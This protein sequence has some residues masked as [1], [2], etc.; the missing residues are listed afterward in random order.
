MVGDTGCDGSGVVSTFTVVF[1]AAFAAHV[2]KV[3]TSGYTVTAVSDEALVAKYNQK[4]GTS[5]AV[6]PS[7]NIIIS[8]A[9]P[10]TMPTIMP[11]PMPFINPDV[12]FFIFFSFG[13]N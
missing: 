2:S 3:S 13:F 11:A 8:P 4:Y 9:T 10:A 12:L 1:S 7:E 5:Y 6:L